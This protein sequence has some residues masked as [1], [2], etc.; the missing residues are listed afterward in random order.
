VHFGID[1]GT[2]NSLLAVFRNGQPELV[3][4]ALGQF[5]TPSVV[6]SVGD[7]LVVGAAAREVAVAHPGQA[8][9]VFKRAMG[10]DKRFKLGKHDYSAPE[11]SAMVLRSL[12][13]DAEAQLGVTLSDVVISVPAYFNALQRRAV[14]LAGEL[15]GLSVRRLVNE[16]T[17]AALAYGLVNRD[18]ERRTLVVDLGGGTFDVSLLEQFEGVMEVNASAGDAFLGGEDFTEALARHIAEQLGV[19]KPLGEARG[20]L[21]ALAERAKLALT[22]QESVALTATIGG[23]CQELTIT[24][25]TFEACTASLQARLALPIARVLN[26]AKLTPEQIDHVV[27][28]GG[29]TRMPLIRSYVSRKLRQFPMMGLDPDHVVAL[30]ASVQAALVAKDEA[31]DDV[32]MTDVAAYTLGIAIVQKVQG[33]KMDGYF[34]P[35][36]ERNT[37]VPVSRE[38]TYYSA[39]AGQKVVSIPVYQGE[40]PLVENNLLLGSLSVPL[41]RN[42]E[43]QEPFR[44]RFTYDASGLLV[45]DV[46]VLATGKKHNLVITKLAG[47]LT[48]E[49]KTRA[50]QAME[51]LKVHP[52]DEQENILLRARIEAC[53]GMARGSDRDVLLGILGEY[54]AALERQDPSQTAALA[55]RI[56]AELDD[57]EASFVR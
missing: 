41:P 50:L 36:I 47:E 13:A 31:L 37:T 39:E 32:V 8:A 28:V 10:S 9:A 45:V 1:L 2:T 26:D 12:K 29:A 20:A 18:A 34:S 48:P 4:N 43:S 5:L 55:V 11:L 7:K 53:Y 19:E 6:A 52:R 35:I 24:R 25:E 46:T 16:P 57:F 56:S 27:L 49:Q 14:K 22:T 51:Q 17:A 15:A 3:P 23:A 30:G 38:Y 42:V 44:V 54:D 33:R 40:S 21:H